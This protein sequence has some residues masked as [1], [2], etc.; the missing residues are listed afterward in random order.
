M[1]IVTMFAVVLGI[2]LMVGGFCFWV[3][4]MRPKDW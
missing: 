4:L 1:D 2:A 3:W